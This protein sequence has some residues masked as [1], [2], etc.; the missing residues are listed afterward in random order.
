[1]LVRLGALLVAAGPLRAQQGQAHPQQPTGQTPSASPNPR[2]DDLQPARLPALPR[3]MSLDQITTGDAIFHG[4]GGCFVCHGVEAQGMPAAGDGITAGLSYVPYQWGPI[5]SLIRNGMPDAVSRSPIAM[6]ARGARGDLTPDE[7]RRAAAY[8]WA[9]SQTRGEPWP[10]GH[11]LHSAYV[12]TPAAATG[13]ASDVPRPVERVPRATGTRGTGAP[14][15][16][17]ADAK[18]ANRLKRSRTPDERG[19]TH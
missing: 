3:G 12:V 11:E 1:M 6:P 2:N 8:V 10:G 14:A 17:G 13:T 9:I 15:A 4:K 7:I 5:D 16:V 18:A 19:G